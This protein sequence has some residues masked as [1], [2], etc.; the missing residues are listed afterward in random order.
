MQI[1]LKVKNS[2]LIRF[3]VIDDYPDGRL[4]I[5]ES[6]KNIPFEIKRVFFINNLLNDNA[7]RG[8]HAHKKLNQIIFCINGSFKLTL[9]D[10]TVEQKIIMNNTFY[11]YGI[12]LGPGLWHNMTEFSKNCVILVVADDFYF[13]DDYIRDYNE[14][15]KFVKQKDIL[16]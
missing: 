6:N 11:D 10:G 12:K 13:E 8:L 15:L 2:G 14:F 7:I 9:D 4:I 3:K 1:K 16:L 5:G